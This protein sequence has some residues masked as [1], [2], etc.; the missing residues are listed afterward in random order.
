MKFQRACRVFPKSA[1]SLSDIVAIGYQYFSRGGLF[2]WLAVV[3]LSLRTPAGS[4]LHFIRHRALHRTTHRLDGALEV[5]KN[6]CRER[7]VVYRWVFSR[8]YLIRRIGQLHW[9]GAGDLSRLRSTD[10]R[11]RD[12]HL[13]PLFIGDL[14]Y[15][16]YENGASV[17]IQK[18]TGRVCRIVLDRCGVCRRVDAVRRAGAR[19][20]LVVCQHDRVDDRWPL[21]LLA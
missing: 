21:L 10:R 2:G 7:A 18:S 9:A 4:L 13:R 16:F 12:R 20:H 11:D 14:E 17:S 19:D 15:Q 8:L 5:K 6:H 3:R 1:R